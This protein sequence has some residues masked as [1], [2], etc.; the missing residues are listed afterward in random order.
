[1]SNWHFLSLDSDYFASQDLPRPFAHFWSLSVEEQFYFV[2]PLTVA[3]AAWVT[4]RC[5]RRLDVVLGLVIG[6]L[7]VGSLASQIWSANFS[8][9]RAYYAT[10]A[11][12]YQ[13]L[14]G[15]L[16]ALL[17]R[18]PQWRDRLGRATP[19]ALGAVTALSLAAF[20]VLASSLLDLPVSQRGVLAATVSV[21]VVL[22]LE[23]AP[24]SWPHGHCRSPRLC[25]W[26][27]CRTA[28]I[29]GIGPC[30]SWLVGWSRSGP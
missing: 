8:E 20:V 21:L 11:R 2:F 22:S 29:Y 30:S 28:R 13:I 7:A 16:A 26:A 19:L 25:T 12:V 24:R 6:G 10:D 15:S 18:A 27:G 23:L 1:M 5:R 9:I 14:V 3:A 4:R 17:L